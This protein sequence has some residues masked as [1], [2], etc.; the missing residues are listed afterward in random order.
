M[1]MIT[2]RLALGLVAGVALMGSAAIAQDF[3]TRPLTMVVPYPAGGP[4]DAIARII[5]EDLGQKLGQN[6]IVRNDAGASGSIGT[7]GVA[8]AE[9][10]GHTIVF[11][12]NQTHGNNMFLLREPGYDA[13]EDF[14]PLAGVGAFEHVYVVRNDLEA[15]NIQELIELAKADPDA[16]NYGSTG[17]GSGSHL[18][19]ELFMERTGTQMT[20]IP[21][22]GAAPLVT[23]LVAGR[24]DVSNSTLPSVLAQ[25]NAGN[26]RAIAIASPE[27]NP[28]LPDLPTL[29]EQGVENAD[30]ES[31]AAIF[32]PAGV[33]EPVLEKLSTELVATLNEPRVAEAIGA[34]GF[35]LNVRTPE[36]FRPYHEQEI[37]TWKAIIDAAGVE[38]Q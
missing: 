12:N 21:F 2:R 16:L 32:A 33:P 1:H 7:R 6:V 24:I 38:A 30:A 22:G 10:D 31:W 20:H 37:N 26:I 28:Q 4:T 27:R 17:I 19:F 9:A 5:A 35:T 8:N 13:L 14:A 11:G 25:I 29:Q 36:E 34:L 23:E 15:E 3:P 18:S